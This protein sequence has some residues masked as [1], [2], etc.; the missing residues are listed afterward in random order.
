MYIVVAQACNNSTE[1]TNNNK[2]RNRF[3]SRGINSYLQF[4]LCGQNRAPALRHRHSPDTL[5]QDHGE[6]CD[7][8]AL[9]RHCDHLH[10]LAASLEI[11]AQHHRRRISHHRSANA[12]HH[13][14]ARGETGV[15]AFCSIHVSTPP[16]P[17]PSWQRTICRVHTG[18]LHADE[19]MHS[20]RALKSIAGCTQAHR[21]RQHRTDRTL[22]LIGWFKAACRRRVGWTCVLCYWR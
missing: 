17:M 9:T 19:H 4:H 7:A 2:K 8:D 12:D 6:Q 13:T 5:L 14:C 18:N 11:Q 21:H 22:F 20:G 3:A 15:V 10:E 1:Q 16:G